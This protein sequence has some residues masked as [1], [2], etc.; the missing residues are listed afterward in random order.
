MYRVKTVAEMIGVPRNTLI[1]WER[2][3]GIVDP[4]RTD[5]GYRAYSDTDVA[6]LRRLKELVDSGLKVSEA[7]AL[8][9]RTDA[10]PIV[11]RPAPIDG[12]DV[13]RHEL[14][15]A[16]LAFDG[17]RADAVAMG[18]LVMPIE[19]QLDDLFFPLLT[20]VGERWAHGEVAVAQE[21]YV[22]AWC[23]ERMLMMLRSVMPT[24]K[25]ALEV[26]CATPAGERH[27]LG[28][29]G[30]AVRLALR[31]FRVVLLG[32]D[33][34]MADLVTHAEERAPFGMCLSMVHMR[35]ASE[36]TSFAKELRRRV[37]TGVRLALGGRAV[38][39]DPPLEVPGVAICAEGVP[40]WAEVHAFRLNAS[41]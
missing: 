6:R 33:V 27:E 37:P 18:L 9:Q 28:L 24:S 5:G 20:E 25:G 32:T 38:N 36:I 2:R 15:S 22:S 23:R 4:D 21:H 7:W 29:I 35:P 39:V 30:I 10:T 34:P 40:P 31:Q 11:P 3:L 14:T 1:A 12:L 16:L 41:A 13:L 17:A 19:S 8:M 26:T